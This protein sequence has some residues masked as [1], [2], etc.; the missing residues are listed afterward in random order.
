METYATVVYVITDEVLRL[1]AVQD[2]P[3]SLMSNAEVL[4]FAI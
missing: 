4:T 2:D 3:Q 1:L